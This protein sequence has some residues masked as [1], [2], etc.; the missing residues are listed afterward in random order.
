MLNILYNRRSVRSFLNKPIE[1]SKKERLKEALLLSPSSRNIRPWEFY[2]IEDKELINTLASSK[3]HGSTFMKSAPLAVIII[4]DETKSDVWIEDCS[5]ASIIL[6][7][8]AE[9]LELGSCWVQIRNRKTPSEDSSEDF[10]RTLLKL[11][12]NFRIE[13]IIAIGYPKEKPLPK[14]QIGLQQFQDKIKQLKF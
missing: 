4:G 6:Q 8:E 1:E 7:L 3:A 9:A 14:K 11:K 13:S 5:I 10:I 2:F 12:P